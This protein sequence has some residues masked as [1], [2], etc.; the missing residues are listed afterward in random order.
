MDELKKYCVP[1]SNLRKLRIYIVILMAIIVFVAYKTVRGSHI[2]FDMAIFNICSVLVAF[3]FGC[4]LYFIIKRRIFDK[5]LKLFES[6]VQY[7]KHHEIMDFVLKDFNTGE[8]KL[9]GSIIVGQDCLIGANTGMIACY[10]EIQRI[11]QEAK[12]VSNY[13]KAKE[14][15]SSSLYVVC[16]DKNYQLCT[17]TLNEVFD[18]EVNQLCKA[19]NKR[20]T[21]FDY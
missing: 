8:R 4:A 6:R 7:F 12:N 15:E 5:Q 1:Y 3:I 9:G 2:T 10:D 21:N 14:G 19:V 20:N 17:I 16:G 18:R 13:T 11:Y